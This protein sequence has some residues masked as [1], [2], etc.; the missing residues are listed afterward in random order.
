MYVF[1][2]EIRGFI[3]ELCVGCVVGQWEGEVREIRVYPSSVLSPVLGLASPECATLPPLC[4]CFRCFCF[5]SS[6][7]VR[8]KDR[9]DKSSAIM[10][11]QMPNFRSKRFSSFYF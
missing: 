2:A 11:G 1:S 3:A 4:F 8:K 9:E 7:V 5:S 6:V 10:A